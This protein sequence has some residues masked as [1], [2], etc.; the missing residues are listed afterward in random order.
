MKRH[1]QELLLHQW[2]ALL[3]LP[4]QPSAAWHRARLREELAERDGRCDLHHQP[5]KFS[6]RWTFYRIVAFACGAR[7]ERLRGVR[8]VVNPAK[9]S[10]VD[11]VAERHGLDRVAFRRWAGRVRMFWPLLP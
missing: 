10:K 2:H 6:A 4:H 8:E 5:S 3:A 1:T 9:A 11:E 7:G